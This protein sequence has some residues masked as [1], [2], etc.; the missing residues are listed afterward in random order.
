MFSCDPES[1]LVRNYDD[2]DAA[3][4]PALGGQFGYLAPVEASMTLFM[5]RALARSRANFNVS[6]VLSGPGCSK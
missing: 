4:C 3:A 2:L 5:P 6:S 1:I